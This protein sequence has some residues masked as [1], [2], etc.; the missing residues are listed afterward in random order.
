MR[1]KAE[2]DPDTQVPLCPHL[3]THNEDDAIYRRSIFHSLLSESSRNTG[4]D[5]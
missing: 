3:T 1:G 2:R 5:W 4:R